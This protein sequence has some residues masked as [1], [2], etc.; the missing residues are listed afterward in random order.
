MARLP[1]H[2]LVRCR[3]FGHAWD[4]DV[5]PINIRPVHALQ[6]TARCLRCTSHRIQSLGY[7]G[8][9][10]NTEMRYSDVY[11]ADIRAMTRAEAK[12]WLIEHRPHRQSAATA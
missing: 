2:Q 7:D 5:E 3:A 9:V 4:E 11:T 8:R 10:I 1:D 12:V 6:Q